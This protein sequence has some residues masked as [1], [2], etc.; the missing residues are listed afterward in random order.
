MI[1]YSVDYYDFIYRIMSNGLIYL[2]TILT[3]FRHYP[4]I[5]KNQWLYLQQ[6]LIV[7][8]QQY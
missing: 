1:L 8:G 4:K 2:L 7:L 6:E 3:G 5:G